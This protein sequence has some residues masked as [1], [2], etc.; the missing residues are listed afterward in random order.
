MYGGV[1]QQPPA[2]RIDNQCEEMLNCVPTL[3]DGVYKRPP[4]EF[5]E[6]L[7][8]RPVGA[9]AN[10]KGHFI[11]RDSSE[12]YGVLFTGNSVEP[13]EVYSLLDGAKKTVTYQDANAKA[14][15]TEGNPRLNFKALTLADSTI[16]ANS[17][18]TPAMT[19]VAGGT[20]Y[21]F[22]IANVLHGVA[23]TT[24]SVYINGSLCSYSSGATDDYTS[25]KTTTIAAA[26]YDDLVAWVAVQ[27]VPADWQVVYGGSCILVYNLNGDDFTFK[28]EDSW[29]NA[30]LV[31]I[32]EQAP[33]LEDLPNRLP[34]DAGYGTDTFNYGR[35]NEYWDLWL[36]VEDPENPGTYL[37]IGW[38]VSDYGHEDSSAAEDVQYLYALMK[39]ALVDD[40]YVGA[41]SFVVTDRPE[42]G[43]PWY[44]TGWE[45]HIEGL[46]ISAWRTDGVRTQLYVGRQH[47]RDGVWDGPI[48]NPPYH[49][50]VSRHEVVDFTDMAVKIYGEGTK[51]DFIGYYL[52]WKMETSGGMN[53]TGTWVETVAGGLY[54]EIDGTT[55]PHRLDRNQD[56]TFTLNR[57]DWEDRKVGDMDSAPN[58]SFIGNPIM[59]VFFHKNRVGFL[60]GG[61]V[62]ISKA[63]EYWDF[64]PTTALEV[65]DDDPI[66][67]TI[68][69]TG[70]D[71]LRWGLPSKGDLLVFGPGDEYMLTSG[72]QVFGAKTVSMDNNTNFPITSLAGPVRCGANVYFVSPRG[73]F[74]AFHEYFTQPQTL[75]DDAADV[76]AHCPKYVPAGVTSIAASPTFNLLLMCTGSDAYVYGYKY[77]WAGDQKAQSAWFKWQ[78]PYT[79]KAVTIIDNYAYVIGDT[80]SQYV[81]EKLNLERVCSGDLLFRV[82]LDQQQTFEATSAYDSVNNL[83]SWNLGFEI[84]EADIDE[85]VLVNLTTGKE[86]DGLTW[87]DADTVRV[88]GDYQTTSVIIGRTYSQEYTFSEFG[89]P[90][91]KANVYNP[92]G[93]L[94][95]RTLIV[96]FMETAMFDLVVTP[97]GTTE[98]GRSAITHEYTGVEVGL[99]TLGDVRLTS[100]KKRFLVW[101]NSVSTTLKLVNDSFYPATWYEASWEGYYTARNR[102]IG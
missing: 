101:G 54:N 5:I 69:S 23:G 43:D 86:I 3:V 38:C 22:A 13:I 31:G 27:D 75:T 61:N 6:A 44:S 46:V 34:D 4:T 83:S 78:L 41:G 91:E 10:I 84:L 42:A 79:A 47:H 12:K 49:I 48:D 19:A 89:I 92:Q 29:G 36:M 9:T 30:A 82:N 40:T 8:T 52:R 73:D 26:L 99:S 21:P 58:P 45:V 55:A 85:F 64:F 25:Y 53:A 15:V 80:D 90:A 16:V 74:A 100:N 56:G 98:G 51:T 67:I 37:P 77:Y 102:S 95:L 81:L 97:S 11:D 17:S 93:R 50:T 88:L 35:G 59:D 2:L 87:V 76:A 20:W 71:A 63:G 18:K 57:I 94:Q 70:V 62:I 60:A 14:Y 33:K 32:K 72:D 66:D 96:S 39:N 68:P 65:L 1:S 24:Y 28:V 7:K